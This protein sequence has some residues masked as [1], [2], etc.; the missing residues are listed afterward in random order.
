MFA[1]GLGQPE[2]III[3]IVVV[4]LFGSAALP[5]FARSLGQA[6]KEFEAGVSDGSKKEDKKEDKKEEK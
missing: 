6:K 3:A 4:V 2:V 5:K 1:A